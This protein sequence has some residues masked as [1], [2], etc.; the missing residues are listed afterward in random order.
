M[1]LLTNHIGYERFG[2][3][4]AL[5]LTEQNIINRYATLIDYHSNQEVMQL[6]IC[7]CE[8]I[9]DWH[10]APVYQ[11]DFSAFKQCGQYY[12]RLDEQSSSPFLIDEGLLFS[13]TFSDVLHYIKSQRCSGQFDDYDKNVP[14]LGTERRVDVRGG[15]YDASGDVSK[16]LSHLSYANY[17][18]PQQIPMLVWNM[19]HSIE[20]LS[21]SI[22]PF[23]RTRLIDEALFGAD[24]LVRMQDE[25]GYFYSTVFDKWS[26]ATEQREIC[27]YQTQQG[28]KTTAYQAGFRQGGGIAIAALAA[29]ASLGEKGEFDP[30]TY[31]EKAQKA[32]WHLKEHNHLYLDDGCENIIDFYCAL[33]AC[34]QL[35]KLTKQDI[36]L[37]EARHWAARLQERQISDNNIKHFWSANHDGSRPYFH[38]AEAGL[39]AI[40]LM[41][42]LSIENDIEQ[43]EKYQ[44]LVINALKFELDITCSTC[45]PFGYPRQYI[46][47]VDAP[48]RSSFFIAQ[49]NESGYWWQG[50]NARLASLA[51]MAYM[52]TLYINDQTLNLALSQYGQN[53]LNW[54]LGLNPFDICM[55]DG[56]GR[57]NPDYL[58]ELGF[59]NAKGGICNGFT[60]GFENE[61]DLAFNPKEH[62]DD[63]LQSWRW[64]EQWTPHA[65]WFLLAIAYQKKA[66]QKKGL[67][68][69]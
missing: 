40:A 43:K 30:Y 66:H 34:T 60:A 53:A 41:L 26:K 31:Q 29:A 8:K 52:A 33:L 58:P 24:F 27:A 42:Y 44:T 49:R 61:H 4:M 67:L 57:N 59:F 11:I 3:K 48:K 23:T 28:D 65:A 51:T 12:I 63:M 25:Q 38:A 69:D 56:H 47:N 20:L 36:Y 22:A 10:I 64:G 6:P 15:W 39:P 13:R 68:N 7:P 32:Y 35:F 5:I 50:E 2:S 14:I 18:N 62:K 46:K 16:Y 55:L 1:Q 45:N 54:I 19:L 21:D 9:D 37:K 17:L